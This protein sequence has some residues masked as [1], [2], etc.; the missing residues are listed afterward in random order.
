MI[1]VGKDEAETIAT[2]HMA[3]TGY[4]YRGYT[5]IVRQVRFGEARSEFKLETIRVCED[6]GH[7]LR[8][9]TAAYGIAIDD[10]RGWCAERHGCLKKEIV[11]W[12][13]E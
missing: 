12:F 3:G 4:R 8:T 6:G 10:L 5:G 7:E 13:E 1:D 9:F 11:F 2:Q